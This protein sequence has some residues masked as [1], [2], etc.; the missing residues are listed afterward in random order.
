MSRGKVGAELGA[1]L[2]A[3]AEGPG[4]A[5]TS[6][7]QQQQPYMYIQS[8]AGA[9]V[10]GSA[11]SHA[12]RLPLKT[13]WQTTNDDYHYRREASPGYI[14]M[15]Q[16]T[17]TLYRASAYSLGSRSKHRR[18]L[19]RLSGTTTTTT[20]TMHVAHVLRQVQWLKLSS[21]SSLVSPSTIWSISIRTMQQSHV[22]FVPHFPAC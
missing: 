21:P 5:S 6:S 18:A 1:E 3:A 13:D 22:A 17:Y 2:W 16:A 4:S 11:L 10:G 12:K 15:H 19:H 8:A 7:Q 9:G 14:R 20:T